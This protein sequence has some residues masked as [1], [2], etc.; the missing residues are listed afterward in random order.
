V[1]L[2]YLYA[3]IQEGLRISIKI[4]PG[5]MLLIYPFLILQAL[6]IIHYL[7]IVCI[8]INPLKNN[9]PLVINPDAIKVR[10]L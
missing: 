2:D 10:T 4:S 8:I 7:N 9:S 6:M 3:V 5:C 1:S